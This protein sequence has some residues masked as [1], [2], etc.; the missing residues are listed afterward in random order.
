MEKRYRPG[1]MV[2]GYRPGEMEKRYRPGEMEKGYRPCE[3]EKRYRP[4]E[5]E[6]CYRPGE[7]KKRYRP[8]EMEKRYRPGEMEKR[9]ILERKVPTTLTRKSLM[10][11]ITILRYGYFQLHQNENNGM[12]LINRTFQTHC[13]SIVQRF[14][15]SLLER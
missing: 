14:L 7:M 10:H 5:M 15:T 11:T 13:Y 12:Y 4:S 3:M 2:K 8:G 1:E 9:Y 6:K